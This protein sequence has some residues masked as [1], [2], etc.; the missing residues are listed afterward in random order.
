MTHLCR[1]ST[2]LA[3]TAALALVATSNRASAHAIEQRPPAHTP[4]QTAAP[5]EEPAI[6]RGNLSY[7]LVGGAIGVSL[8]AALT[9]VLI[10][11]PSQ[12]GCS[13]AHVPCLSDSQAFGLL[14]G[15]GVTPLLAVAGVTIA[16][17]ASGA[18][19]R[20]FATWGG[21]MAGAGAGLIL[22]GAMTQNLSSGGK[23]AV[24]FPLTAATT[25]AGALFFYRNSSRAIQASAAPT[26]NGRGGVFV[27]SGTM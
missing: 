6:E 26:L 22:G 17:N 12:G 24:I 27:V 23:Q 11:G 18:N 14:F 4:E 21:A 1:L 15:L 19:G 13:G 10:T 7:E 2:T 5:T 20:F 16:G 8:G 25:L 9:Y 3:L